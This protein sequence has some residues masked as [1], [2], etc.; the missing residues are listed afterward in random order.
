MTEISTEQLI[1]LLY[2]KAYL[3]GGTVTKGTVKSCLPSEWKE[4]A[5][6]IYSALK[7]QS[8][9]E[10]LTKEGKPTNRDG[11]FSLT[12]QGRKLLITNLAS[13][14]YKFT[15]SK[16]HRVLNTLLACIKE[17]G[18]TH[19]Q[20]NLLEGMTF[21][22]FQKEFKALYFEERRQQELRGVVAVHSQELC[23][24]FAK[25]HSISTEKLNH[26]FELLKA[27]GEILSVVE[28]DKELIQWV[29]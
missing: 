10:V 23:Q 14:D 21:D 7:K 25:E 27:S 18:E 26:Y 2:A 19:P 22:E 28:K 1:Y 29:E 8:L 9:I 11:R 12:E 16:G 6:K 24:K 15:T 3:E 20:D 13:T 5:E 17:V 4:K